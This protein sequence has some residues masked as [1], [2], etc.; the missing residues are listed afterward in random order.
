MKNQFLYLLFLIFVIIINTSCTKDKPPVGMY[1]ATFTGTY[2]DGSHSIPQNRAEAVWI[3]NSYSETIDMAPGSNS[4]T[5]SLAKGNNKS[6]TGLMDILRSAGGDKV[7]YSFGP[8]IINGKWSKKDGAY[9]ITGDFSYILKHI[10]EVNHTVNPFEV[11]G[12]FEITPL[13][14]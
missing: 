9:I 4:S 8:I 11:V 3:I 7:G 1:E 2:Q 10:D 14:D 5:F 6:I 12:T 13:F